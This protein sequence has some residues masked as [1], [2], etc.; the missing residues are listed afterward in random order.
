MTGNLTVK[1]PAIQSWRLSRFV[2]RLKKYRL[3][4]LLLSPV[5]GYFVLFHYVPMYGVIIAF[6]DYNPIVGIFDSEW[7]GLK[8]FIEFVT[9]YNFYEIMRNTVMI[10]V[11]R[12]VF[13]F[14]AP[15][16]LALLLN[17][18]H[19]LVFKKAAQTVLYL[20]YF[21]SWVVLSG[22]IVTLLSPTTGIFNFLGNRNI[23]TDPKLFRPIVV[24]SGIWQSVGYGSIVFLA[25]ISAINPELYE[26]AGMEGCNRFQTVRF[27][28]LPSIAPVIVILFILSLASILNAGFDQIF[29]L[30][31]PYVMSVAE[32][33]DTYV[34][35][36]GLITGDY[37]FATAV[38]LF[39]N[40]IGLTM[41]LAANFIV[42][43]TSGGEYGIW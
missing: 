18:L 38:G 6:K 13:G 1:E 4:F 24:I 19:N 12:I 37:S 20:P 39:K 32:I 42:S 27:I 29:N 43:K 11:L 7:V 3:L 8:H 9:S 40:M 25:T 30:M 36:K 16:I 22:L 34:Y 14:P 28:T 41:V 2:H 23:L 35:R 15:I 31:N 17:E 10:S 5:I 33:I 26:A 21:M